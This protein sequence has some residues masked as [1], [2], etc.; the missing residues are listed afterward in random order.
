MKGIQE[1]EHQQPMNYNNRN[2]HTLASTYKY[3]CIVWIFTK[4]QICKSLQQQSTCYC[5]HL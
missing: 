3:F 5:I 4:E 2:S 1:P